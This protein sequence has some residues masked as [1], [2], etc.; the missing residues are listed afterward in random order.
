MGEV[1]DRSRVWFATGQQKLLDLLEA[2]GTVAPDV[3]TWHDVRAGVV[4]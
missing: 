4:A 1:H 2:L 3:R